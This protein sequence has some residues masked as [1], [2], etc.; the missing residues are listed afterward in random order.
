MGVAHPYLS[1]LTAIRGKPQPFDILSVITPSGFR[2]FSHLN[3][4]WGLISDIQ[5]DP[6]AS[7]TGEKVGLNFNTLFHSLFPRFFQG[8]LHY[9][10]V[11]D[12]ESIEEGLKPAIPV[13]VSTAERLAKPGPM[14]H[15]D[16]IDPDN[17]PKKWVTVNAAFSLFLATNIS[18]LTPSLIAAPLAITSDGAFDIAYTQSGFWN[19]FMWILFPSRTSHLSSKAWNFARAKAFILEP[20]KDLNGSDGLFT[21]DGEK[22]PCTTV[23]CEVHKGAIQV[24]TPI[25]KIESR[26]VKWKENLKKWGTILNKE[27]NPM[28]NFQ[29]FKFDL[30]LTWMFSFGILVLIFTIFWKI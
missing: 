4:H 7:K 2:M 23:R 25:R 17:L 3:F 11:S 10:P 29:E 18:R 6:S 20:G 27:R 5:M 8:K 24:Q 12:E 30:I 13:S 1:T 15:L 28:M 19:L 22:I 26:A 14:D 21:V 9:L 16:K